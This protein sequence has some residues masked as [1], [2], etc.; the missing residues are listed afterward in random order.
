MTPV[1]STAGSPLHFLHVDLDAFY[2]SV[3]E[4]D[5]PELRG[6]PVVVGGLGP[7]GVVAAA[8]YPARAFG[9]HSAMPTAVARRRCPQATFLPPRFDEYTAKSGAV[10]AILREVTPL[11]EPLSLDEAFLDVSG[12]RRRLGPAPEIAAA[13]RTRIR[14]ET[15]LVASVGVASTKQ[16]AKIASDLSKPDGLLVVDPADDLG[17][18]HALPVRRLWGVGPAT[19]ARLDRF[20]VVTVGDLARIPL[21]TLVPTLGVAA[22]G[23]LHALAWNRDDRAVEPE[24]ETKSIGHEETFPADVVDRDVLRRE[25]RRL[26]DLVGARLR[27]AGLAART[28]TLKLRYADFS[29][30]TRSSTGSTPTDLGEDIGRTGLT[31]LER[32]SVG[33]G[34]RLIGVSAHGLA[35]A[36]P[37][38]G[39]QLGLFRG[40]PDRDDDGASDDPERRRRVESVLDDVRARFG[41]DALGRAVLVES[42]GLR[43]SRPG[44]RWGPDR[45]PEGDG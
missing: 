13:I 11:V 44:S 7:R 30:I 22:A 31:L 18:L 42:D 34:I 43:T 10:M 45:E 4:L 21:E 24:R 40:N 2:A 5:R 33:D 28:V 6:T 20:G 14:E 25:V 17:F 32:E 36:R 38:D 41:T 35:A 27:A 8:N 9:V 39:E 15:G 1:S 12:A 3:E 37:P 23:H 29:T 19:A 16:L 26:A